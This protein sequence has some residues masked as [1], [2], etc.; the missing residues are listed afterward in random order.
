MVEK[1]SKEK[2][3]SPDKIEELNE[4]RLRKVLSAL[5]QGSSLIKISP[6]K[7]S[8]MHDISR[9]EIKC[10]AKHFSLADQIHLDQKYEEFF[11]KA[12]A[13]EIPTK[14][15]A[16]QRMYDNGLWTEE[17]EKWV[18][19]Q[20]EFI[21]N[22]EQTKLKLTMSAQIASVQKS[23]D[24]VEGKLKKQQEKRAKHIGTTCESYANVQMNSYT[25]IYCLFSDAE[26]SEPLFSKEDQDY[27]SHEDIGLIV[28]SYNQGMKNL[29]ISA[30]K[31]LSVSPFFTSYFS[32]I[33]ESP[34]DFFGRPV[35]QLS[36]YQLNLLSYARVLRSIIKN[37]APP[38]QYHRDPDKLFEWAE[39]GDKARKLMEKAGNEDKAFS[40]VGAKKEDYEQAGV[41][42][43]GKDIFD[44][45]KSKKG[46]KSGTL[47]IMDFLDES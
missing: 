34:A 20:K 43:Q 5:I 9:T 2:E 8:V 39:K 36:F 45:A 40:M 32:L 37:T 19:A 24:G 11:S 6:S 16:L 33:E 30:V 17:N 42:R 25:M 10:Y 38:K 29:D 13:G 12:Q 3:L 47:S 41:E 44:L 1:P 21:K 14:Q 26:C 35:H 15:E 23:I 4:I 22:L 28:M 46:K 31:E 27:L 7:D 18:A